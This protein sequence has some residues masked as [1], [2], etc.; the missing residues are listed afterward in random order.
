MDDV[1]ELLVG[2]EAVFV[3]IGILHHVLEV[4]LLQI[5]VQ[6]L[7]YSSQTTNRDKA[8]LLVVKQLKKTPH[9]SL[10]FI[11]WNICSQEE[12]ESF[13]IDIASPLLVQIADELENGLVFYIF[14]R[15][16][17]CRFNIYVN[18]EEPAGLI[19]PVRE[20]SKTSKVAFIYY[21][22]WRLRPDRTYCCKGDT[23]WAFALVL[24]LSL[25]MRI[26]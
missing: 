6:M 13:K 17:E 10:R 16:N 5:D 22:I 20:V 19:M 25:L 8:C 11:S 9:F 18:N 21:S 23:G 14:S 26:Q 12:N 3:L 24:L 15:I 2:N 1:F 7:A 4:L